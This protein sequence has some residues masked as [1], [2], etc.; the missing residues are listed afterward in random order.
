MKADKDPIRGSNRM[1]LAWELELSRKGKRRLRKATTFVA[2]SIYS[3][4]EIAPSQGMFPVVAGCC[5]ISLST[6]TFLPAVARCF[7]ALRPEWC[8]KWC[9]RHQERRGRIASPLRLVVGLRRSREVR[10]VKQIVV[11][12]H[13]PSALLGIAAAAWTR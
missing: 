5:R 12:R 8:Q 6:P 9:Q 10:I 1:T 4:L 2:L 3:Q 11:S 13:Q 7:W